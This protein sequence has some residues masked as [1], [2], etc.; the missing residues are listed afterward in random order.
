MSRVPISISDVKDAQVWL[1][2]SYANCE[3]WKKIDE[4]G[5]AGYNTM[6][7]FVRALQIELGLT[8]DGEFGS[9][10][11][12]AFNNMFPNGLGVDTNVNTEQIENI[13]GLINTSLVC[14]IE[15]SNTEN[16]YIYTEATAQGIMSMMSQL[17]IINFTGNITEK[18]VKALMTS[19]AYYLISSGNATT[20]EIQQA[21]NRKYSDVL[22]GYIPTNGLYERNMNTAIIKMIQYEIGVKVDGGWGEGTKSSLPVLGAGSSRKNLVY[23]LQYLLYLNGFD[24]NG[25]D[26]GFGNGVT[27][28]LKNFQTLMM[29]DIDGYCGRQVWSALV[30]SCGDTARSADACDTCF[31]ITPARAKLLKNN[32]YN[33]VGRYLTGYINETR[34]KALQEGELETIFNAD[35]GVFLIYQENNRQISDFNYSKG[36]K[37]GLSASESAINKRIPKD[38][39]I[40]F[41]VDLDVYEEQI[42]KIIDY[43]KGINNCIDEKYRVGIYAPRLVCQ[44][45]TEENLAVSSFVADMSSGYSCNV[46]QKIPENWNFDQFKEISNYGNELDIDKV[47]YRGIIG[48]ISTLDEVTTLAEKNQSVIEFLREAYNLAAEYNGNSST[49]K[50]NNTLVIQYIA[51]RVY[52]DTSWKL[53]LEYD[54]NG[55]NY[56]K[57]HISKDRRD[58]ALYISGYNRLMSLTHMCASLCCVLNDRTGVGTVDAII[59]DLTGWAGDLIQFAGAYEKAFRN[60]EYPNYSESLINQ[61]LC[62]VSAESGDLGFDLEDLL[63]DIDVWLL[64]KSLKNTRIDIVFN[65]FYNTAFI[66]RSNGFINCRSEYGNMPSDVSE[67]DSKYNKVYK[68][69]KTYLTQDL[70]NLEGLAANAFEAVIT[71]EPAT[72]PGLIE[73]VAKAFANKINSMV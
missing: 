63:Q 73:N 41:A 51:Y 50:E 42:D 11:K 43:F 65:T 44:R 66:D 27:K 37:A 35:L 58:T 54:I 25:F 59:A 38:A 9:A 5:V 34:P 7:A 55:I 33:I 39:V 48:G 3:G 64:Y 2:A 72:I 67:S 23:I 49:V 31:E 69:A 1:N 71:G 22:G 60:S 62:D 18:E 57:Q 28:A 32:G 26:G 68:L 16:I 12:S 40:Y 56:I 29:L 47:T 24:P 13:I 4:D 53:L 10:T 15:V 6:V 17:G 45:V 21:I 8:A 46:G 52:D 20:R 30:V 61:L 70:S 36:R 14:R 19:D